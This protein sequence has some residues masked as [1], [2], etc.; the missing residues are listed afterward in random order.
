MEAADDGAEGLVID[1]VIADVGSI[2]GSVDRR[3]LVV[4]QRRRTA[5]RRRGAHVLGRHRCVVGRV[6]KWLLLRVKV[7]SVTDVA[8][9]A[10]QM[11]LY[12]G[13]GAG[14]R[15][16]TTRQQGYL[17][18]VEVSRGVNVAPTWTTV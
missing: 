9:A 4:T 10:V 12:V 8:A 17:A 7:L 2:S 14:G 1:V 18:E 15:T 11:L 6:E 13:D 16:R 5:R 3:Q